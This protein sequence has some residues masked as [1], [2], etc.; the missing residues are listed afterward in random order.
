[1]K[2]RLSKCTCSL[3]LSMDT[4]SWRL[5]GTAAE[6]TAIPS[7][8]LMSKCRAMSSAVDR[9]A[10]AVRPNRQRT[11]NRSLSTYATQTNINSAMIKWRKIWFIWETNL[12]QSQVTGPEVMWPF[13][14][15]VSLVDTGEGHR[16]EL[17]CR[18]EASWPRV[19]ST[20]QS[21]R[22][23][24]QDMHLTGLYLHTQ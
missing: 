19:T 11:P 22:R 12:A 15:T 3:S 8:S 18:R 2:T 23:Q 17:V 7:W 24:Q 16:G 5:W 13:R 21:F 1:M 20:N 9:V 10:V 6:R 14:H 4:D